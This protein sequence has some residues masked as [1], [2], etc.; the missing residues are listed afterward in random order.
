MHSHQYSLILSIGDR[1][2]DNIAFVKDSGVV[3]QL[4]LHPWFD[5][6]AHLNAHQA[7]PIRLTRNIHSLVTPFGVE[8]VFSAVLSSSAACYARPQAI[9]KPYLE[10]FLREELVAWQ[11][12]PPLAVPPGQD[13]ISKEQLQDAVATNVRTV[14]HRLDH[15]KH[16]ADEGEAASKGT[17]A[18][19]T[20]TTLCGKVTEL[21][22]AA[23]DPEKLKDM[24]PAWHPWF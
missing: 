23:S 21:I 22:A 18:S 8:S 12:R 3:F 15:L 10:L 6:K 20:L 19:E 5:A 2:L 24:P 7:V 1:N 11:S 16:P 4:E 14:L 17:A 9:L 13:K